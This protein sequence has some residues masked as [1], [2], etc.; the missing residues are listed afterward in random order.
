MTP[1]LTVDSGQTTYRARDDHANYLLQ[2]SSSRSPLP[3]DLYT[4]AG[5]QYQMPV[6]P[7]QQQA[8]Q[9]RKPDKQS[10]RKQSQHKHKKEN[11]RPYDE[12][13]HNDSHDTIFSSIHTFE[14][15]QRHPAVQ[16][17]ELTDQAQAFQHYLKNQI[18]ATQS[19][20]Q[21]EIEQKL[22]THN[23]QLK[24]QLQALTRENE[25]L[26]QEYCEASQKAEHET[27]ERRMAEQLCEK[28][29]REAR[30][31]KSLLNMYEELLDKLTAQN[32][33]LKAWIKHRKRKDDK[34]MRNLG[35][36][37]I[38]QKVGGDPQNLMSQS[39]LSQPQWNFYPG[40]PQPEQPSVMTQ[41][42]RNKSQNDIHSHR[43]PHTQTYTPQMQKQQ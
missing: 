15:K 1:S 22:L 12:P 33:K 31:L 8:L 35:H 25:R 41:L 16:Q 24:D 43:L 30:E 29:M 17:A 10:N 21:R 3:T 20:V 9:P 11:L 23:Y 40:P 4:Q 34:L 28:L 37:A 42:F 39:Q 38:S 32:K 2:T 14:Q 26:K 36:A 13:P 19:N 27:H 18:K 6:Q 5:F 7:K